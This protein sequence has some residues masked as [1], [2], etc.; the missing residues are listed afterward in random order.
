MTLSLPA[1]SMSNTVCYTPG[2]TPT[3]LIRRALRRAAPDE[4]WRS[5]PRLA[6]A[7]EL[8]GSDGVRVV[9]PGIGRPAALAALRALAGRQLAGSP[10]PGSVVVF[11][12]CGGISGKQGSFGRPEVAIGDVIVPDWVTTA[13]VDLRL[14]EGEVC[15]SLLAA[16]G[17]AHAEHGLKIHRG[18]VWTVDTLEQEQPSVCRELLAR[19]IV[20]A[21]MELAG[22]AQWALEL[23]RS[24]LSPASPSSATV[25]A[26]L[27]AISLA[28][29]SQADMS[30][31][32]V[33]GCFVVSDLLP[34]DPGEQRKTAFRSTAVKRSLEIAA[35]VVCSAVLATRL[36]RGHELLPLGTGSLTA[37][38]SQSPAA[39][40]R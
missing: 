34:T 38:P 23:H 6:D 13:G 3:T 26:S 9:G 8:W 25:S 29:T 18:G 19:G 22:V 16:W 11:G 27:A 17:E 20:G 10:S 5:L 15:R 37:T 21:D 32:E 2:H 33:V 31:A 4:R 35:E 36:R 28:G 14:P 40:S 7:V 24:P 12:V 1:L 39:P 30:P